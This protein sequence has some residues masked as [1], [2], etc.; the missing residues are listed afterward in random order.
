MSDA[1]RS[2]ITAVLEEAVETCT[3]RALILGVY[4]SS[5]SYSLP[6][7]EIR[8]AVTRIRELEAE[9]DALKARVEE[10]EVQN[11]QLFGL[12]AVTAFDGDPDEMVGNIRAAA[13]VHIKQRKADHSLIAELKA[14]VEAARNA[15]IAYAN[16]NPKHL[17]NGVEQDPNGVH[18][19]LTENVKLAG[20]QR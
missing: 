9:R 2:D 17:Y 8:A 11:D 12:A 4:P 16:E 3:R 1:S 14:R 5:M 18:A 19:W 13:M 20:E 6:C 10:L 15:M 7:D